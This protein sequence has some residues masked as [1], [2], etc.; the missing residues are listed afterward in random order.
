VPVDH[1]E[2]AVQVWLEKYYRLAQR[3]VGVNFDP[4][5]AASQEVRYWAVHRELSGKPDKTPFIDALTDLHSTVFG[6]T[7][8][9]AR[10]SAEL[11]VLANNTV[12]LIT[13]HTSTD[14]EA[15]WAKLRVYLRDCYRSVKRA[16]EG[17]IA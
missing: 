4:I 10:E 12:D 17:V 5:Q 3:Y 1:D 2:H 13:S 15:D 6:I 9:Q 14:P 11:R 16:T 7:K 8:E